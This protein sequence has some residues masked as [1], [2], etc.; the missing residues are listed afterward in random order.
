[1]RGCWEGS[2]LMVATSDAT[3]D[4]EL[5]MEVC[6]QYMLPAIKDYSIPVDFQ[7]RDAKSIETQ[8]VA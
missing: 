7:I 2:G 4:S 6:A 5:K 1:M 3:A 8:F